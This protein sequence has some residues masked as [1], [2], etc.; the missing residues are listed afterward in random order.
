MK[1]FIFIA[2]LIKNTNEKTKKHT[3]LNGYVCFKLFVLL[4]IFVIFF[5]KTINKLLNSF[6]VFVFCFLL[7]VLFL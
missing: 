4:H 6:L 1:F 7:T 3:Q 5:L 2:K